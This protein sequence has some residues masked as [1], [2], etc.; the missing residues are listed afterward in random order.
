MS[1]TLFFVAAVN[2]DRPD[3]ILGFWV[4]ATR[5]REA[6]VRAQA[7]P[8]PDPTETEEGGTVLRT[9]SAYAAPEALPGPTAIIAGTQGEYA[10]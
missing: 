7:H 8:M 2:V 6:I 9:W 5:E 3:D 10:R 4:A 1:N